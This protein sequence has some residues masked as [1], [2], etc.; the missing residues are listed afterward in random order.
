M[1]ATQRSVCVFSVFS[2]GRRFSLG[3]E[4]SNMLRKLEKKN[5]L[6]LDDLG[7]WPKFR[8][9]FLLMDGWP[10]FFGGLGAE[11]HHEPK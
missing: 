1:R 8:C 11:S 4:Q 2:P 6:F 9:F 5:M 3:V 10:G 7:Y